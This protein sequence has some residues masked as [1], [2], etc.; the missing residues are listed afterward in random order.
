[1][2]VKR[3]G[4]L[5][6]LA[7]GPKSAD[8]LAQQLGALTRHLQCSRPTHAPRALAELDFKLQWPA[9]RLGQQAPSE[10]EA[11]HT[12]FLNPQGFQILI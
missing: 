3:T 1:M 10:H 7:A 9:A 6:A 5:D 2:A 12:A 8:E 4:V 11:G